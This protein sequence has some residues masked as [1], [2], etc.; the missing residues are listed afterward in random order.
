[1]RDGGY[2]P[3]VFMQHGLM[4][5]MWMMATT[6]IGVW[7]WKSKTVRSVWD[8]PMYI[9][10]PAMIL[11]VYLC[12]SRYA[13]LLLATGVGALYLATWTKMRTVVVLLLLIPPTYMLLRTEQLITGEAM[14]D[15]AR[16]IFSAE[17]ADS[18][19]FRVNNEKLMAERAMENPFFGW[20][21]WGGYRVT[22]DDGKEL[23]TD[24]LFIITLG[25]AGWVGLAALTA[26]LLLPMLL[27]C[28]DWRIEYWSHP[29]V[30]PVIVLGMMVALY[31]FDHLMNGMVNPIFMLACGAVSA[32]HFAVPMAARYPMPPPMMPMSRPPNVP[33]RPPHRP[34]TP[35]PA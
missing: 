31:M 13:I 35:R 15:A 1:M 22:G 28:Y 6:L 17:R 9:L 23:I 34:V 18:L 2:R 16:S 25:K 7:L 11:T 5:G 29:M 8:V 20:G 21:G 10:V 24:S 4:V 3:M 30:A 32:A 27:V 33:Q 19:A 12:K 14:I 26:M